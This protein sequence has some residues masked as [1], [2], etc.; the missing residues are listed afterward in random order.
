MRVF[1]GSSI[2]ISDDS[3]SGPGRQPRMF[4]ESL[5]RFNIKAENLTLGAKYE[6]A[7]AHND[8]AR[9]WPPLL[10]A[11]ESC[12]PDELV[13]LTD[14]WDVF[15]CCGLDEIERKFECFDRPIIFPTE[16]VLWPNE[17][18]T[19]GPYPACPRDGDTPTAAGC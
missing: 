4:R 3:N 19:V 9:A 7:R 13:L 14:A 10:R 17:L 6:H 1:Y 18:S 15:F 5:S 16:L 2:D 11:L 12:D 8:R